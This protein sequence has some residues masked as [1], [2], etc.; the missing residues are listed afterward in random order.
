MISFGRN[1]KK[2]RGIFSSYMDVVSFIEFIKV[3][4]QEGTWLGTMTQTPNLFLTK[5]QS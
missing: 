4:S 5:S 1:K 3:I 2:K